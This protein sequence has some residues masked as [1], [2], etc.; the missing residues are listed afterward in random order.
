MAARAAS[1]GVRAALTCLVVA[2]LCAVVGPAPAGAFSKSSYRVPVTAPDE[3][4]APVTIEADVY[5]PD[6]QPPASGWPL[7]QVLHGGGANK[8]NAYD[9]GHAEALADA[10]YAAIV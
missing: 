2:A 3:L 10:G 7:V 5:L 8:D 6:G 1:S 4:G 9:G